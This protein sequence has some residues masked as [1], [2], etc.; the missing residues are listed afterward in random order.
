[1]KQ[2]RLDEVKEAPVE[3]RVQ[4]VVHHFQKETSKIEV[5]K[6]DLSDLPIKSKKVSAAGMNEIVAGLKE[7]YK[8]E[9]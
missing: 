2:V 7:V 8:L 6:H 5:K 1:M 9:M 4:A 3:K